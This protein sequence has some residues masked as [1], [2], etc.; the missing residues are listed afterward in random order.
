MFVIIQKYLDKEVIKISTIFALVYCLMFN[1]AIFVYKFEY[2]QVNLLTG[3]LELAK[4]FLYNFIT[5]FLIFFG[6]SFYR[7]IF[8]IGTLLLFITGAAASY[9]LFFLGVAPSLAIMPAI[10]GTHQTEAMELISLRLIFWCVFSCIVCVY[11]MWRYMP[12]KS[13]KLLTRI[14]TFICLIFVFSNV[15][16]PRHSFLRAYFPFQYL[17]NAYIFLFAQDQGFVKEDISL[18]YDVIDNSEEDLLGILVLG[19]SARYS[20]FGI[21]GYERDTTPN[22]SKV[23]N[24]V[25]YKAIACSNNTFLS[26]PCMLS[27]FGA[28]DLAKVEKETSALSVLT[29]M[30]F[31]TLWMGTQSIT[32]YYRN[33]PGGSFYDEVKFHMIPGGSLVFLPN[34]LDGKMLPYFQQS[35][36]EK[37]KKF[38]VIHTTGSHWNYALRY[39]K[40]FEKYTPAI[41]V[42]AKIDASGCSK[43]E[44]IN[45]Y[46]NSILYTDHFLSEVIKH[47]KN[48]NAF[49]IYASDHGESLGEGG[50]LTHGADGYFKEQMEVPVMVWFS[51]KYKKNHPEKWESVKSFKEEVI[52]H[53]YIFHSIL[54]CVGIESEMVDKSLSLCR[55]LK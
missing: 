7:Y 44:L 25:S 41:S 40:E 51:E 22:L 52:S 46:D 48:K 1:S 30:G 4:D 3:V 33:K 39:P 38:I 10:F 28:K 27:R 54:D 32:K 5:L 50:R 43:E 34:D 45:S 53:D 31:D 9:Y 47:L 13:L 20:N 26:V 12:P 11:C 16:S 36:Q 19:E 42:E 49:L 15:A 17:H 24:L 23:E 55:K 6:L 21:N 37:G 29:K 14:L 35:I 2:Y 18:K 8:V